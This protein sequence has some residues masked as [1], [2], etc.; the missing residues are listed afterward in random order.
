M[1]GA[2]E[3]EIEEGLEGEDKGDIGYSGRYRGWDRGRIEVRIEGR[4]KEGIEGKI[5]S[6]IKEGIVQ[7]VQAT[8]RSYSTTP[9]LGKSMW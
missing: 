6:R 3:R 8:C 9:L 4:I 5:E 7:I 2:K 1:E